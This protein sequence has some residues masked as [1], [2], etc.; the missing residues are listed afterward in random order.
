MNKTILVTGGLGY[1]GSCVATDL[2][3]SGYDVVIVDNL[4][5]SKLSTLDNI[6][7]STGVK[8]KFI[9][10]DLSNKDCIT[11]ICRQTNKIDVIVHFAAHKS[12]PESCKS[13]LKYFDNNIQSTIIVAH[14]SCIKQADLIFSSS[15]CVYG[16]NQPPFTTD[17]E[18]GV[19]T[20]P[21]G[22]TKI[23]GEQILQMSY[24]ALGINVISLRYFNP[25]GAHRKGLV[26]NNCIK[27]DKNVVDILCDCAFNNGKEFTIFG[28]D[29]DTRDGTCIRDYI[30]INDLSQAHLC[31]I[32][33]MISDKEHTIG[34]PI[35]YLSCNVGTGT[36]VTVME[37][38][39]A[40][41]KANNVEIP[42]VARG[43]RPGDIS[44]AYCKVNDFEGLTGFK[45]KYKLEES[46][47][48]AY[49][50]YLTN[51]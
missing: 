14:L 11:E 22:Q 31:T 24:K 20:N 6:Y 26:G 50:W 10:A 23:I 17:M 39:Q 37:L 46:L 21:Y 13:P 40:F 16:D 4:S 19:A 18:I 29:W 15:C 41:C 2:I 5:N 43:R 30:D 3:E 36:G 44:S 1:I 48:S 9:N 25:I 34:D 38:Y 27:D 33:L 51:K 47:E 45:C 42:Y 12:V 8:P 49:T 32:D 35:G 28:T 7:K